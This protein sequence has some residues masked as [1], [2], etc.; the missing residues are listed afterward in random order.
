MIYIQI[1]GYNGINTVNLIIPSSQA[2]SFIK[3]HQHGKVYQ[4]IVDSYYISFFLTFYN[5]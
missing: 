3:D 4:V 5:D 2:D 1:L